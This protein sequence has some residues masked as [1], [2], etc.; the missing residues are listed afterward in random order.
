MHEKF[1]LFSTFFRKDRTVSLF[2][3]ILKYGMLRKKEG[4]NAEAQRR[5][6]ATGAMAAI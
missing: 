5:R 6:G 4:Y 1:D 3:C 2:S